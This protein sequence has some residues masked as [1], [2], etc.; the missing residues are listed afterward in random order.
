MKETINK[1][2]PFALLLGYLVKTIIIP[3]TLPDSFIVASLVSYIVLEQ[4][5]LKDK[6]LAEYDKKIETLS[7]RFEKFDVDL[8][9]VQGSNNSVKA[10]LAMKPILGNRI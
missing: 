5:R 6:K 8:K 10:A 7:Q 2:F 1:L 9:I 3:A 4:L